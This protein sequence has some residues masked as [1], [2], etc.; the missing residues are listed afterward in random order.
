MAR[1]T[2]NQMAALRAKFQEAAEEAIMQAGIP[3]PE[4]TRTRK[5][6]RFFYEDIDEWALVLG[7]AP[8]DSQ[9]RK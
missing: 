5:L 2:P 3:D 4:G 7:F 1:Y 8:R 6:I 9:S